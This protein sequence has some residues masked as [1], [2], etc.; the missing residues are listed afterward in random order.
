MLYLGSVLTIIWGT[1]HLF[2]TK[3][4]V[5]DFGDISEAN[6]NI[7]T[8][9]WIVEGV[10]LIFVGLLCGTIT[11]ADYTSWISQLVYLLTALYL[12]VMSIVSLFTSFKVYFLCE[13]QQIPSRCSERRFKTVELEFVFARIL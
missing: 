6:K 3:N 2:P 1:A 13:Q 10:S 7:I 4:V 5:K 8:M 12:V 11:F 9:E